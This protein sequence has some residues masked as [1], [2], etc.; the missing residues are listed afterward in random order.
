MLRFTIAI[1]TLGF[2]TMITSAALAQ[3]QTFYIGCYTGPQGSKGIYR[4]SIDAD[5]KLSEPELMAE[6]KNPSF[7]TLH[8]T[9]PLLYA[10]MEI[11]EID[12]KKSGGMAGF[13]IREDGSLRAINVQPSEGPGA[14]FVS[15]TPDGKLAL[16]ANYSGGNVAALP[17]EADGSLQPAV[18]THQH[19]GSGPVKDRQQR[20][21]AHSIVPT[22]DGTHAISADLGADALYVYKLTP[23]LSDPHQVIVVPGAGPRHVAWHPNGKVAYVSNEL[24]GTVSSYAWDGKTLAPLQT[25]QTL[26]GDYTGA[27]KVAEIAVHPGGKWVY[28]TNRGH[29]SIAVY[30]TD[31]SGQLTF[32]GR[33][34]TLGHESRHFAIDATGAFMVVANQKSD[35]IVSFRIDP[36]TG[37]PK[38]VGSI[39]KMSAPTCIRFAR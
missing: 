30:S 10:T 3:K 37:M 38:P 32:V 26:P 25:L 12:G 7:L 14:C 4:A 6:V 11:G 39:V 16:V 29:D 20:A 9:R 36:Q 22:P 21:F 18:A 19:E 31:E 24:N 28:A 23:P 5:G 17:I 34:A 35:A 33:E 13:A 8:P 15:V 1:L 27:N 2:L